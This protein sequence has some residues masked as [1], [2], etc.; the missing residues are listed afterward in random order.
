MDGARWRSQTA[1]GA[2]VALDL[3]SLE[4]ANGAMSGLRSRVYGVRGRNPSP[5]D[6]HRVNGSSPRNRTGLIIV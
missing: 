4:Q 5:L 1:D 3:D 6:D 2:F